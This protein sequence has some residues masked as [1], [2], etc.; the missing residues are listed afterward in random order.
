MNNNQETIAESIINFFKERE[1]V[2]TRQDLINS[3]P[4]LTVGNNNHTIIGGLKD[5]N[6][7]AD[8]GNLAYRLT[9]KGW[10]FESFEKLK[11]ESKLNISLAESNID[12]N[13]LNKRNSNFNIIAMIINFVLGIINIYLLIFQK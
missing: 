13:K 10:N 8:I 1:G 7:L 12:A 9:D 2:I 6:L 3:I 5:L 4:N 11:Y